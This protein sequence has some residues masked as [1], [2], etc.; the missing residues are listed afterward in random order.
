MLSTPFCT[1][2]TV[3]TSAL[4]FHHRTNTQ[5]SKRSPFPPPESS[6]SQPQGPGPWS[7]EGWAG[8]W[9]SSLP[10][11]GWPGWASAMAGPEPGSHGGSVA[12][13]SGP[14]QRPRSLPELGLVP[15]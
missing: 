8:R 4:R 5:H 12:E 15:S 2:R 6:P 14:G 10:E 1:D 11:Q 13:A 9:G 3:E 7:A